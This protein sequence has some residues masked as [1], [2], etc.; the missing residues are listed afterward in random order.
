MYLTRP[1][2]RDGATRI[3]PRMVRLQP[4][5]GRVAVAA[6]AMMTQSPIPMPTRRRSTRSGGMRSRAWH[7]RAAKRGGARG[8]CGGRGLL[9]GYVHDYRNA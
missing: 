6:V 2:S 8:D 1:G 5:V 9:L 4:D 7:R 3:G